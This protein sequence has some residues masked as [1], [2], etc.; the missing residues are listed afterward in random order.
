MSPGRTKLVC[1]IRWTNIL[2][3][4]EKSLKFWWFHRKDLVQIYQNIP[5]FK[6]KIYFFIHKNKCLCETM[7]MFMISLQLIFFQFTSKFQQFCKFQW[8]YRKN[9]IKISRSLYSFYSKQNLKAI[10]NTFFPGKKWKI[11]VIMLTPSSERI[12]NH[13]LVITILLAMFFVCMT[14]ELR[15]SRGW[16]PN[17]STESTG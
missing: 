16:L 10:N 15:L 1:N 9:Y 13:M 2:S 14:V 12:F 17:Q 4:L 8:L 6:L 3:K 5:Y 7:K 11:Q